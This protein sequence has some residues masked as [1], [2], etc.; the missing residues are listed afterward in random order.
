[1]NFQ[2][3]RL[4]KNNWVSALLS[5]TASRSGVDRPPLITWIGVYMYMVLWLIGFESKN[6]I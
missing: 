2:T 5:S 3:S 1:M 6:G 4:A